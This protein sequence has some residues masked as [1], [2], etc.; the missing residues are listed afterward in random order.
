MNRIKNGIVNVIDQSSN[1]DLTRSFFVD[2][3]SEYDNVIHYLKLTNMISLNKRQ[4]YIRKVGVIIRDLQKHIQKYNEDDNRFDIFKRHLSEYKN[5][6]IYSTSIHSIIDAMLN[7]H[8]VLEH[9]RENIKRG[10]CNSFSSQNYTSFDESME[11]MLNDSNHKTKLEFIDK[12]YEYVK[13]RNV[14][15]RTIDGCEMKD[16]DIV[17]VYKYMLKDYKFIIDYNLDKISN[18][19]LSTQM[20][21]VSSYYHIHPRR[22]M[23]HNNDDVV[24][25]SV[26]LSF[27]NIYPLFREEYDKIHNVVNNIEIDVDKVLKDVYYIDDENYCIRYDGVITVRLDFFQIYDGQRDVITSFHIPGVDKVDNIT[28]RIGD[29]D[30]LTMEGTNYI[31]FE[32]LFARPN[33]NIVYA[34]DHK[35]TISSKTMN[36]RERYNLLQRYRPVVRCCVGKSI[37]NL[38]NNVP[39][40]YLL[41]KNTY[42]LLYSVYMKNYGETFE[43]L[44]NI[45]SKYKEFGNKESIKIN[46]KMYYLPARYECLGNFGD[47]PKIINVI[48]KP[49]EY[50]LTYV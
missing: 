18:I 17:Q 47:I 21:D 38:I 43:R 32:Y 46:D 16:V 9:N 48:D 29:R 23:L 12:I 24:N 10:M 31:K 39:S 6:N 45:V 8:G 3:Q 19:L 35:D 11:I 37:S 41:H 26:S 44:Y 15:I 20:I 30:I 7:E 14:D 4:S 5:S 22:S 36:Q 33:M 27:C 2:Y 34:M 13:D 1:L 42:N 50:V 49:T 28:L 40:Y 25:L